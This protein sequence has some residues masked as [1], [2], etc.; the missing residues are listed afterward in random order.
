MTAIMILSQQGRPQPDNG[1]DHYIRHEMTRITELNQHHLQQQLNYA[2]RFLDKVCPLET[3]SHQHVCSYVVYYQ[4]LLA[5]MD[6][7]RISGLLYPAQFVGLQGPKASPSSLLL[8]SN[9]RHIELIINSAGNNGMHDSA[10]IEDIQLQVNEPDNK[11]S[12]WFSMLSGH[13]LHCCHAGD[14]QFTGK[15]GLIYPF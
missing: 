6:D 15:D 2:K 11:T 1:F 5:F 13:Q 10:G 8:N 9:N 14:K 7:G 4:H 12:C 3:G